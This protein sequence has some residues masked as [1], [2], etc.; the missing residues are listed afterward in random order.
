M[1]ADLHAWEDDYYP[2]SC[3]HC[4]RIWW[5][6]AQEEPSSPE[7][8]QALRE[9]AARGETSKAYGWWK[10]QTEKVRLSVEDAYARES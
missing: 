10:R 2:E 8:A 9:M 3:P 4:S 6:A 7:C 1:R 5:L